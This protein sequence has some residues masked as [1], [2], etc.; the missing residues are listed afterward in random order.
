MM[1]CSELEDGELELQSDPTSTGG[2][3]SRLKA[4]RLRIGGKRVGKIRY[5]LDVE[6]FKSCHFEG[7]LVGCTSRMMSA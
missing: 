4:S 2:L 6:S 5:L 7:I 1:V 3:D